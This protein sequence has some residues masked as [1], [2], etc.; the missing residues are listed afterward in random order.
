MQSGRG[1]ACTILA[2]SSQV[3]AFSAAE[4]RAVETHTIM[5]GKVRVYRRKNSRHW[6]CPTYLA[7]NNR[8]VST[9]EDSPA[10]VSDFAEDRYLELRGTTLSLGGGPRY[11]RQIG[12]RRRAVP[13]CSDRH[14]D[15]ALDPFPRRSEGPDPERRRPLPLSSQDREHARPPQGL[16]PHPYPIPPVPD[17]VPLRP[18]AGSGR[19]LLVLSADPSQRR[20]RQG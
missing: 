16:A 14:E 2:Q 12:M 7:G 11:C 17:R 4:R 18:R 5:D 15:F 9:H 6:Q 3:Q 1:A 8:R 20:R 13:D 19:H 10:Q